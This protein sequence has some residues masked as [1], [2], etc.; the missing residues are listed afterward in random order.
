V[1]RGRWFDGLL[2]FFL[3]LSGLESVWLGYLS[4]PPAGFVVLWGGSAGF[5]GIGRM[6]CFGVVQLRFG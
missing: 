2:D 5:T 6:G 1:R 3:M 4:K